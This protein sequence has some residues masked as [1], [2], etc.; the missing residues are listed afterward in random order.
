MDISKDLPIHIALHTWKH[1]RAS[2]KRSPQIRWT[3]G[4]FDTRLGRGGAWLCP[5]TTLPPEKQI[6]AD[7][8]SAFKRFDGLAWVGVPH[9]H[10]DIA[11]RLEFSGVPAT[12]NPRRNQARS[13]SITRGDVAASILDKR[14]DHVAK[15]PTRG[16]HALPRSEPWPSWPAFERIQESHNAELVIATD[17]SLGS[18]GLASIAA[19]SSD[20]DIA[21]QAQWTERSIDQLEF[22]GITRA[23]EIAAHKRPQVLRIL[24][25]N[26]QAVILAN[27]LS[28]RGVRPVIRRSMPDDLQWRFLDAFH[29]TDA[30]I[31]FARVP[32][33]SGHSLNTPADS[34]ARLAREAAGQLPKDTSA[35]LGQQLIILADR[36]ARDYAAVPGSH[37]NHN[38]AAES[39]GEA[40]V[41]RQPR[42]QAT[43]PLRGPRV[44]VPRSASLDDVAANRLQAALAELGS[45]SPQGV[46]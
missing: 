2:G 27:Q 21:V 33:H 15:L 9:R 40:N 38:S 13:M 8:L 32:G 23:M 10:R 35:V 30:L 41:P 12:H 34:A 14:R 5:T 4:Y 6:A 1:Y 7:L 46:G 24:S 43:R 37:K 39:H 16:R 19:I 29:Q 11:E 31:E 22:T 3:I 20:G 28:I 42:T 36:A 25:D 26:E 18:D 45:M 17:A 44:K